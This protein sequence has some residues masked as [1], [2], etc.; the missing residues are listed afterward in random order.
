MIR[1]EMFRWKTEI[2]RIIR[3]MMEKQALIARSRA[4]S[5]MFPCNLTGLKLM[6]ISRFVSDSAFV[7][8]LL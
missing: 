7:T 3:F 8:L 2:P 6:C 1:P 4:F 5:V